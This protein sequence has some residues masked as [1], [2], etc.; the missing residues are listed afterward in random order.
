MKKKE[1]CLQLINLRSTCTG[2][3]TNTCMY[4]RIHIAPVNKLVQHDTHC[5]SS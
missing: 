3:C 4:T 1:R 5:A 2:M